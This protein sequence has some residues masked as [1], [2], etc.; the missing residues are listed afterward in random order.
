MLQQSAKVGI[1]FELTNRDALISDLRSV[2]SQIREILAPNGNAAG[3]SVALSNIGGPPASFAP[4][5][6]PAGPQSQT[7]PW[8]AQG[9]QSGTSFSSSITAQSITISAQSVT[10]TTATV[11]VN[12][13]GGIVPGAAG[14]DG[15]GAGWGRG[16]YF[17]PGRYA[18]PEVRQAAA[19]AIV[20]ASQQ[21]A[22]LNLDLLQQRVREHEDATFRRMAGADMTGEERFF[23]KQYEAYR[24]HTTGAVGPEY[25]LPR[26]DWM[27]VHHERWQAAVATGDASGGFATY[28]GYQQPS[29]GG[30]TWNQ[31]LG[32]LASGGIQGAI[33]AVAGV[34]AVQAAQ[35]A[36]QAIGTGV[37]V[38]L[39]A[40]S[41]NAAQRSSGLM[42]ILAPFLAPIWRPPMEK[43]SD[44]LNA[45]QVGAFMGIDRAGIVPE[46][47]VGGEWD[48]IN[49]N[50]SI[51]PGLGQALLGG[52]TLP[53]EAWTRFGRTPENG[54]VPV[55]LQGSIIQTYLQQRFTPETMTWWP[56]NG[57]P[58]FA[59]AAR[60][61]MARGDYA[62]AWQLFGM[63]EDDTER[64]QGQMMAGAFRG[65]EATYTTFGGIAGAQAGRARAG[66][67]YYTSIGAYATAGEQW[68]RARGAT[69]EERMELEGLINIKEFQRSQAVAKGDDATVS[70]LDRILAELETQTYSLHQQ[71]TYARVQ[72]SEARYGGA[73]REA[74]L[75]AQIGMTRAGRMWATGAGIQ[76]R[77]GELGGAISQSDI[78]AQSARARYESK[79]GTLEGPELEQYRLAWE[80]AESAAVEARAN[81]ARAP[82]DI[83]LQM[84][85]SAAVFSAGILSRVPG[86]YGSVRQALRGVMGTLEQEGYQI[87]AIE[88][89]LRRQPGGITPEQ[90]FIIQQRRQDVA[91]RQFQTFTELSYGWENR[92]VSQALGMPG[93][94]DVQ[95]RGFAI[96]DAVSGWGIANP[97]MGANAAQLPWFLRMAQ[98]VG[99]PVMPGVR[100]WPGTGGPGVW[101]AAPIVGAAMSAG[102]GIETAGPRAGVAGGGASAGRGR[103]TPGSFAAAMANLADA[104]QEVSRMAS[105]AEQGTSRQGKIAEDIMG[106]LDE[107]LHDLN[108][109][110]QASEQAKG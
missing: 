11:V 80:Q 25:V 95:A 87:E 7:T 72:A 83:G 104:A 51:F 66:A 48:L 100:N 29:R 46:G 15:G 79:I 42:G 90:Q 69:H 22:E 10:V 101:G 20:M 43:I 82:V 27:S 91:T 4:Y 56:M 39:N 57:T 49:T 28:M 40:T 37:D 81:A 88:A 105:Q 63:S 108:V 8:F 84:R 93:S 86:S 96:A 23:R 34:A 19:D 33:G 71:E 2:S 24:T 78:A 67:G 89:G 54:G 98:L 1:E 107:L 41:M 76:A 97:M 61:A 50:K 17:Q 59:D 102:P 68:R 21:R 106:P 5:G 65:G 31:M 6:S 36:V 47:I 12:A 35:Q 32:G 70:V 53:R 18:T 38:G 92:L 14:G 9:P 73:Q 103:G 75:G 64:Y 44:W 110:Y 30:G 3:G 62:A 99:Q 16:G 74:E 94:F 60:Q 58:S 26:A 55:P 45:T 13:Q 52:A 109:R 77:M 85:E